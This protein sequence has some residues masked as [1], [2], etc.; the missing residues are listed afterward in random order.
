MP[1]RDAT[2]K[3]PRLS[4]RMR[5][6]ISTIDPETDPWTGKT[7]FRTSQETCATV[8]RGG[9]VV[10]TTESIPPG[11]R[12]LLELEIPGGRQ[13]QAVGRVAWTRTALAASPPAGSGGRVGIG[14]EFV[15][16]PRDQRLELEQ[17]IARSLRRR[18]LADKP[19]SGYEAADLR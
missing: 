19:G 6:R 15:G 17:F 1:D 4:V 18:R 14:V 16:G 7:F 10:A 12:V 2:Q 8:S 11:R 3:H 9:A 5:A 13:I